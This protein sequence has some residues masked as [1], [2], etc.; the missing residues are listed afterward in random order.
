MHSSLTDV[1]DFGQLE[2]YC[3]YE[4]EDVEGPGIPTACALVGV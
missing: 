1:D 4:A 2:R 3:G